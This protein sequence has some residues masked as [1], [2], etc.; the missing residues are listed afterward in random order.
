M[1]PIFVCEDNKIQRERLVGYINDAIMFEHYDMEVEIASGNPDEVLEAVQKKMGLGLY[2]LDIDLNHLDFNGFE[3]AKEIRKLDP[4]GFI[5]FFTTHAEMT[6]LTFT[7]KIEAMDYIVKDNLSDV[8]ER[9]RACLE[10]VQERLEDDSNTSNYFT[11]H[12]S[13]K[14]VI[15]EKMEDI[16]FFETSPKT[17]RVVMHSKNRQVEFYAKLKQ[18]E[19]SLGEPFYRCHR[20]FL[21]NK[22]NI[23]EVD[24]K[25]GTITMVNGEECIASNK[26]IKGLQL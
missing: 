21:V 4:R 10:S 9:V 2:F 14:K 17:H 20:S 25:T 5:V 3:L 26:L 11:F 19:N 22:D 16:L 1:L 6:Y 8:K 13:D 15:H 23:S 7:Y 12:V 24:M 18:I